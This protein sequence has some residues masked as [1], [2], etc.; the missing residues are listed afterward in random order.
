M[1]CSQVWGKKSDSKLFRSFATVYVPGDV[2]LKHKTTTGVGEYSLDLLYLS[3]LASH[4]RNAIPNDLKSAGKALSVFPV[5]RGAEMQRADSTR[6]LSNVVRVQWVLFNHIRW[7]W[8][9]T[10]NYLDCEF[11]YSLIYL[12][13]R[14]NYYVSFRMRLNSFLESN[15]RLVRNSSKKC[16]VFWT[17][18]VSETKLA[19]L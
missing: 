19:V 14:S 8:R 17:F 1:I 6:K 2:V 3:P 16:Y 18:R 11:L 13:R 4:L 12:L 15:T 10:K 5:L 7:K 9:E